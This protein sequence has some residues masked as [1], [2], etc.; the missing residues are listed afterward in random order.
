MTKIAL[1]GKPNVGKSSLFNAFIKQRDAIVSDV[2]GTTRDVK[3]KEVL[4]GEKKALLVDTGGLDNQGEL[5]SNVYRKTLQAAEEADII[6]FMVDGKLSP[7]D[8]DKRMFYKLSKVGKNVA[9]LVNKIDNEKEKERFW[10]FG[11]FG[12]QNMFELSIAHNKG[13]KSVV[14]WLENLIVQEEILHMEEDDDIDIESFIQT[15]DEEQEEDLREINVSIIGRVNVGKSS[16][17]NALVKD[18]RSIVSSVAG[19]TIDPVD[20]YIAYEGKII[21]FVDTAGIRRRGKIDGIEKYALMRTEDMLERSDIAL[22]VL[23]ASEEFKD[24]DE[25][26][27][28]LVDKH[29]LGCIIVLNKWDEAKYSYEE[30]VEQIRYRFKFL[31]YAPIVTL[32]AL[33]KKRVHKLPDMILKVFANYTQRLKT[34]Q[35]NDLLAYATMKHSLPADKTKAVKIYFGVQFDTRPPKIALV[36]NRPKALHFSYKRYLVNVFR[37]NYDFEGVPLVLIPKKRGERED[38]Q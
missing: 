5:F 38:E 31:S 30:A 15:Q 19:T 22:V 27:A 3:Q 6:L 16:L 2:S 14:K 28:G 26:I 11:E 33:S 13:I 10:N 20:E 34:A 29:K 23:D 9:L 36:M 25:K 4:F 1:I 12:A 21:N 32:S 18:E 7:C 35:I 37:E 8:D 17:L 24:L